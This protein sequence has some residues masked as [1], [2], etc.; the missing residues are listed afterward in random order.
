MVDR[1]TESELAS[2]FDPELGIDRQP[3]GSRRA[4]ETTHDSVRNLERQSFSLQSV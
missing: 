2:Q 3:L 1:P 4:E